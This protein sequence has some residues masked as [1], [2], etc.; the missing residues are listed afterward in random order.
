MNRT[1]C[2]TVSRWSAAATLTLSLVALTGTA[3]ALGPGSPPQVGFASVWI[4]TATTDHFPSLTSGVP[5]L[6]A[7]VDSLVLPGGSVPASVQSVRVEVPGGGGTFTL[8]KDPGDLFVET[9]YSVNLTQAGVV[10]F[11]AGTYTFTVTDTAGGESTVTDDLD[12]AAVP[13]A[14][15][16]GVAITGATTVSPDLFRAP[17]SSTSTICPANNSSIVARSIATAERIRP[18]AA[19]PV[20]SATTR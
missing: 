15:A 10:G 6:Q 20:T 18:V 1:T 17:F 16:T 14:A 2:R 13:L 12:G 9:G 5:Q 4:A 19:A 8:T 11:P 3:W 7:S